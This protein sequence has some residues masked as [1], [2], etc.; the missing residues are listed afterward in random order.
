MRRILLTTCAL[1]AMTGFAA[2][3][4][5]TAPNQTAPAQKAPAAG[6]GDMSKQGTA[7]SPAAK[8]GQS[9]QTQS[10]SQAG[11]SAIRT[12]D[13]AATM[14]VTFYTVQAADMRAS[15]LI[16]TDVYN[17]QNEKIG[18]VEDLILDSGKNVKAVVVSVGG[19]LGLGDRNVAV[20]PGSVVLSEQNDGSARMVIN[21]TKEELKNA[22]EFKFADVD[23][24]GTT[25]S[26][27]SQPDADAP[28]KTP[29]A[30]SSGKTGA[31]R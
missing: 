9:A 2:A 26:T 14:R 29:A 1:V 18:E 20:Q 22:P 7:T 4:S 8:S 16:D 21:T 6:Q 19:F 13:K 31:D 12:V 15:E 30:D 27:S 24:A 28:D 5:S 3:Q 17:L 11:Q 23:K 25:G 10:G